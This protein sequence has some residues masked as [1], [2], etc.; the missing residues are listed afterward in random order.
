MPFPIKPSPAIRARTPTA[1]SSACI[2]KA[3]SQ[4]LLIGEAG[5]AVQILCGIGALFNF[6]AMG[7][8]VAGTPALT[9]GCLQPFN[10]G[11][12]LLA[13]PCPAVPN[14]DRAAH[15][16]RR[17]GSSIA[18]N[19]LQFCKRNC[20]RS[21]ANST[22][23]YADFRSHSSMALFAIAPDSALSARLSS[24]L[25][26][27]LLFLLLRRG[28]LR[29]PHRERVALEICPDLGGSCRHRMP[30]LSLQTAE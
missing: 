9:G 25:G 4:V 24:S 3:M 6:I 15:G 14:G 23:N 12:A 20:A 8:L 19:I 30:L 10:Y 21:Q 27:N 13:F 2:L 18:R 7:C 22:A 5:I 11:K 16:C 1:L 28:L 26:L 17:A 29:Q